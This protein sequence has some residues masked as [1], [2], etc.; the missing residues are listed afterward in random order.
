MTSEKE[1]E[2][3][4]RWSPEVEFRTTQGSKVSGTG[5]GSGFSHVE[6]TPQPVRL[7]VVSTFRPVR[8]V[9][10]WLNCS[11]P[12]TLISTHSTFPTPNERVV[13]GIHF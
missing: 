2:W 12:P 6:S 11:V 8:G 9:A 4:L 3:G 5:E 7:V 1:V 10:P 13:G